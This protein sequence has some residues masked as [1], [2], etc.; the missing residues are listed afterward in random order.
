MGS[1]RAIIACNWVVHVSEEFATVL[2]GEKGNR[3]GIKIDYAKHRW[4]RPEYS[5]RSEAIK[6]RGAWKKTDEFSN[7][8]RP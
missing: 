3:G 6:E 5:A 7:A 8:L 1:T 2:E 4:D